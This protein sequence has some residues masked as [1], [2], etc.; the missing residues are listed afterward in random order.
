MLP[1]RHFALTTA[2]ALPLA[3]F[4]GWS[5]AGFWAAA[6]LVDADRYFWYVRR[7][8]RWNP[9]AA[10][11]QFVRNPPSREEVRPVLHGWAFAALLGVGAVALPP[12]RPVFA[13][14]LFHHLLDDRG[15]LLVRLRDRF[16]C[17]D[18][19]ARMW[20][21]EVHKADRTAPGRPGY[22]WRRVALCHACHMVAHRPPSPRP[23]PASG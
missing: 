16:R 5:A 19:G 17:R 4:V 22:R 10:Y 12:L 21:L 7:H 3:P 11:R 9:V 20:G 18:C 13:G 14:V 2:V 15:R 23:G 8:R 6:I 1:S